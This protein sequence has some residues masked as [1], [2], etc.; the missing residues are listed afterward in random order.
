MVLLLDVFSG[1][2]NF[3]EK[4]EQNAYYMETFMPP[5]LSFLKK[6]VLFLSS[7]KRTVKWT[8]THQQKKAYSHM[9]IWE[10]L[11]HEFHQFVPVAQ[12]LLNF[13]FRLKMTISYEKI[14]IYKKNLLFEN[15]LSNALE[16]AKPKYFPLVASFLKGIFPIHSVLNIVF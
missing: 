2:F 3:S 5:Y 10:S 15:P 16:C 4:A 1:I 6:Q 11:N 8:T 14:N 9:S 7:R 13:I 12:H